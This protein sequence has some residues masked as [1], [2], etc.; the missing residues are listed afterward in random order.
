MFAFLAGRPRLS[1]LQRGR[2]GQAESWVGKAVVTCWGG[3]S[4]LHRGHSPQSPGDRIG[5]TG[6]AGALECSFLGAGG[7]GRDCARQWR[8]ARG[9]VSRGPLLPTRPLP[10][11]LWALSQVRSEVSR[12]RGARAARGQW[13]KKK[14]RNVSRAG[15]PQQTADRSR[16]SNRV[17]QRWSYRDACPWPLAAFYKAETLRLAPGKPRSWG[18]CVF[19]TEWGTGGFWGFTLSLVRFLR[20]KEGVG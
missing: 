4:R 19:K 10:G 17:I 9:G 13:R 12:E 6:E 1:A 8:A 3:D 20:S 11:A 18:R 16:V 2:T 15:L 5:Q 14:A 7:R